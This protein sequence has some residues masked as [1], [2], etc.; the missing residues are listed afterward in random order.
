MDVHQALLR[1]PQQFDGRVLFECARVTE[2]GKARSNAGPLAKVPSERLKGVGKAPAV[3]F[4]RMMQEGEGSHLLVNLLHCVLE[5]VE[6]TISII[7]RQ[8]P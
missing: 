1:D 8:V 4:C 7:V 5:L 6:D 3:Q 2:R